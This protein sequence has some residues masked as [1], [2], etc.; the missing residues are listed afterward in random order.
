MHLLL[1]PRRAETGEAYDTLLSLSIL[2]SA[3]GLRMEDILKP[4]EHRTLR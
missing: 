3:L 1:I 4:V 2:A